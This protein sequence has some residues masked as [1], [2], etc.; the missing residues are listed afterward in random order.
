MRR[1]SNKTS[2]LNNANKKRAKQ[3]YLEAQILKAISD[4]RHSLI[5]KKFSLAC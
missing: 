3:S 5:I 2:L 4:A 1:E